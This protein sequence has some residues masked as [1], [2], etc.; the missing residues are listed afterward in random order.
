VAATE[1]AVEAETEDDRDDDD[2]DDERAT[3]TKRKSTIDPGFFIA[4][5]MI[6][7]PL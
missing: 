7:P 2:D 1:A 5:M 3:T 6:F 4:T